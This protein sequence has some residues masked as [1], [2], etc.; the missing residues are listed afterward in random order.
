MTSDSAPLVV[1][2]EEENAVESKKQ[3]LQAM[4][5][6]GLCSIQYKSLLF[7]FVLFILL[8]SDVFANL[9]LKKMSGTVDA[10]GYATPYGTVIQGLVLVI[11][12]MILNFFIEQKI[13]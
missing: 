5:L 3:S 9:V 6:K 10:N 4:A 13:I 8:T 2:D 1:T 7:L 12:H 11:G